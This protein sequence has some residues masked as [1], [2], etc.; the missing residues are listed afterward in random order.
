MKESTAGQGEES[1]GGDYPFDLGGPGARERAGS[2]SSRR[3]VVIT[4]S[5]LPTVGEA[6]TPEGDILAI[7]SSEI[8]NVT[9]A[10]PK[11]VKTF[12]FRRW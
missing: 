11:L 8:S 9:T 3:D 12:Y 2:A 6:G 4:D 1:H 7:E 10:I 5:L